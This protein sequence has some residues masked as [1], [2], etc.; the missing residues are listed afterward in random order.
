MIPH[1][2]TWLNFYWFTTNSFTHLFIHS[3][4][5]YK[6]FTL[7]KALFP[8]K[9]LLGFIVCVTLT[10]FTDSPEA[11][12][13]PELE[14]QCA[15]FSCCVWSPNIPGHSL[16]NGL[17]GLLLLKHHFESQ[18]CQQAALQ[19]SNYFLN[20]TSKAELHPEAIPGFILSLFFLRRPLLSV[21]FSL[22]HTDTQWPSEITSLKKH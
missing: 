22:S 5:I 16:R 6:S 1:L 13:M 19:A 11:E 18:S 3:F 15:Y 7:G 20:S 4:N 8:P 12:M 2:G 21:S 14:E 10:F 17:Q 9:S